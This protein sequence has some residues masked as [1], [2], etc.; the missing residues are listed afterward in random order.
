VQIL[1]FGTCH[2]F[3]P[4]IDLGFFSERLFDFFGQ[5]L[6]EVIEDI[7]VFDH[8]GTQCPQGTY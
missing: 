8:N 4:L 1:A 6:R 7:G 2:F 5:V 3:R